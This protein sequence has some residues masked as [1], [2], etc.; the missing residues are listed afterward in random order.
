MTGWR[1]WQILSPTNTYKAGQNGHKQPFQSS[2]KWPKANNK[3]R[4]TYWWRAPRASG[5]NC[6]GL[7]QACL[8]L[9]RPS[10][11]GAGETGT[12]AVQLGLDWKP[13][14]SLL[15]RADL[16]GSRAKNPFPA[17]L[18]VKAANSAGN[19]R[20]KATALLAS[21]SRAEGKPGRNLTRR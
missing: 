14:A 16:I 15:E 3:W 4:S 8:E 12:A 13:A 10:L 7:R 18:S 1:F 21:G 11:P 6:G 19:K 5:K 20:G 9:L 17:L 2:K